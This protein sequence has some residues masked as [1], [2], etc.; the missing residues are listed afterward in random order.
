[1]FTDQISIDRINKLHPAIRDEVLQVANSLWQRDVRFRVTCGLRTWLEQNALFQIGRTVKTSA[2][3]VTNAR[4]GE[5]YHNYGLAFDFCIIKLDGRASWLV[6]D[7]WMEVVNTYKQFGYEWGGDWHT[8]KD[9]PH[10][11]KTF[12][13]KV[14]DL[15][16]LSGFGATTYPVIT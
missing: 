2:S 10:L 12:G 9:N 13:K 8:I 5:S 11:K 6:D 3:R 1:M 4:A 16:S 7:N 15:K 14:L